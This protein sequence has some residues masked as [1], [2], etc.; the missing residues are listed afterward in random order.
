MNHQIVGIPRLKRVL[1][2]DTF[3]GGVTGIAGLAG[4]AFW[5][6]FLGLPQKVLLAVSVITFLYA[7]LAL[8]LVLQNPVRIRLLQGLISAN[9]AWAGVSILLMVSYWQPATI[10]GAVFL[11]LQVIVVAALAWLEGLHMIR[12]DTEGL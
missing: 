11:V 6:D 5:S 9:W 1:W 4:H 2:A 7:V 8:A 12:K 10:W 3:L